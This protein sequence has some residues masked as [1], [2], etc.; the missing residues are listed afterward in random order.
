MGNEAESGI[1][2]R[3]ALAKLDLGELAGQEDRML[4]RELDPDGAVL[5]GG[6]QQKLAVAR[7]LTDSYEIALLD[8]PSA[9]LDPISSAAMLRTVLEAAGGRTVIMISH[10]MS[11]SK[12]ADRVL[13]FEKGRLTENGPHDRL[14]KDHRRYAAFFRSQAEIF[15]ITVRKGGQPHEA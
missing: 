1:A 14:M 2:V 7:L 3:D 8:E 9:A 5:S 4:G 10:D 12:C 6:Q 15:G 13:F 11:F